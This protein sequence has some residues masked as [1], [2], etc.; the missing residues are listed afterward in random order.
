MAQPSEKCGLALI[1]G[2][3]RNTCALEA[4]PLERS[5]HVQGGQS[6]RPAKKISHAHPP[7]I[8]DQLDGKGYVVAL[9][10]SLARLRKRVLDRVE[11]GEASVID[12]CRQAGLSRSRY[13][14]LRH[15]YRRYGEAGL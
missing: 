9:A 13:Y 3:M 10:E 1:P 14:E 7:P 6:G 12:A 5:A 11:R 8:E 2:A 15:R 4:A